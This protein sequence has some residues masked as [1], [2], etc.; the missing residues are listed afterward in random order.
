MIESF[1]KIYTELEHQRSQLLS[2]VKDIPTDKFYSSPAPGKWSISQVL[3]HILT[4]ESLSIGYMKKKAQGIDQ[5]GNSGIIQVFIL[6][7]LKI[8]QRIPTLK[9]KAPKVVVQNTPAALPLNEVIQ[10]WD[11]QRANLKLFLEGIEEK[12]AKKLLYKHPIAGRLDARQALIFFGEHIGHH[13]PQIKRL[14]DQN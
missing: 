7:L 10:K 2:Q 6:E 14:L 5:L 1:Q 12:N 3:T 11:A 8:S 9:F 13:L 4:A